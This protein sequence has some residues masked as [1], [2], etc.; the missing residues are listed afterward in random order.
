MALR[1]ALSGDSVITRPARAGRDGGRVRLGELVRSADVAVTNL[2]VLPNDFRGYA[3]P[4]GGD[5]CLATDGAIVN[6]LLDFG[7]DALP[8]AN[9]HSL[10]FGV[11]GAR[12]ALASLDRAG[13]RHSG[14]GLDLEHASMPC[15]VDHPEGR[16][17]VV[18]CTSSF[19]DGQE[20]SVPAPGLPPRPGISPLRYQR[21]HYLPGPALEDLR[22][23]HSA[24]GLDDEAE[25]PWA[26][27]LPRSVG[28]PV[29]RLFGADFLE[30]TTARVVTRCDPNDV[31]RICRW[32]ECA[33]D[34]ADA[35]V[36]SVHAHEWGESM[37]HP[38]QFLRE[39]A[40]AVIDQGATVV[41]GHGPHTLRGVEVYGGR[42]IFYSLGNFFF[43]YEFVRRLPSDTY[44]TLGADLDEPPGKAMARLR[45]T[46]YPEYWQS[47][48][49]VITLDAGAVTSVELYPLSLGFG[50]SA[51]RRGRPEVA[52][53]EEAVEIFSRL[54]ELSE[55]LDTRIQ[56]SEDGYATVHRDP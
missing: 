26:M 10:D 7:F 56:L 34:E 1:I 38:P 50:R 18:A 6:E 24:L 4:A 45:F 49:P 54:T 8:W 52:T 5:V 47:I 43:E 17:A 42:P 21:V 30:G 19:A 31:E 9:N 46:D 40:R 27:G 48:M 55:E 15:Y 16:V 22:M 41:M 32:V 2:E 11:A 53:P 35:I 51:N 37:R 33:R 20:A 29:V 12:A 39:F 23:A 3:A 28:D 44:R 14:V 36:V 13:A 25:Y